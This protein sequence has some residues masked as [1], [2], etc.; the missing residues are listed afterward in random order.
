MY[1]TG[2]IGSTVHGE[3]FTFDYDLP[4]DTMYCETCASVGLVFFASQMLRSESIGEYGDV[5]ERA[6]YNTVL[7]GTA[8]DGKH[9][10]Y[11]NPLEVNPTA[12]KWDPGKSHVKP[13]RP[14][15][16]GCACCP[17]NIARTLASLGDYA[18]AADGESLTVNLYVGGSI[19][20]TLMGRTLKISVETN[21]PFAGETILRLSSESELAGKLRLRIPGYA[22]DAQICVNGNPI[23]PELH[24]GYAVI[25]LSGGTMEISLSF[26]M[27]ARLVYA[28]PRVTAD[29]GKCA[30]MKGPLVYCLEEADNGAGLAALCIDEKVPLQEQFMAD[31]FGGTAVITAQG[32]RKESGDDLYSDEPPTLTP[33]QLKFVPYCY[34]A[35]REQGEMRVWLPYL[36]Y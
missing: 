31:L 36:R 32:W 20:A 30:V 33:V 17:P 22:N 13:V 26:R 11:V 29:A 27:P 35:N 15:W 2:G 21:M 8:L 14:E 5:M 10:F 1:I 4:N 6:L 34:W 28:N 23:C 12:S 18:Y 19:S 16:L 7:A 25:S 24:K 9:F 3:A